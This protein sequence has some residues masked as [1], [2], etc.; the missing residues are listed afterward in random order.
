MFVLRSQWRVPRGWSVSLSLFNSFSPWSWSQDRRTV[1]RKRMETR[2][3]FWFTLY[4][5]VFTETVSSELCY[6]YKKIGF[7]CQST[8]SRCFNHGPFRNQL[9][10]GS[11]TL[12][13]SDSLNGFQ[14]VDRR[15]RSG[16]S[17]RL[18]LEDSTLTDSDTENCTKDFLFQGTRSLDIEV[19]IWKRILVLWILTEKQQNY[20]N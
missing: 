11:A 20:L 17:S 14:C 6:F 4:S 12:G 16:L 7:L 8:F 10:T 1:H 19:V 18:I 5:V 13:L 2:M 15:H 3:N 9:W